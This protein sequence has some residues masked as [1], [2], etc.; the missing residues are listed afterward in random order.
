MSPIKGVDQVLVYGGNPQ[1]ANRTAHYL[2]KSLPMQ[3]LQQSNSSLQVKRLM[4]M[5]Y[6]PVVPLYDTNSKSMVYYW[7]LLIITVQQT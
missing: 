7:V 2:D 5:S 4:L 6:N 1:S 3:R